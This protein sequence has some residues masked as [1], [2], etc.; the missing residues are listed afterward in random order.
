M[1]YEIVVQ[2]FALPFGIG[3][4]YLADINL[5]SDGAENYTEIEENPHELFEGLGMGRVS[6]YKC[7]QEIESVEFYQDTVDEEEY[8]MEETEEE[9]HIVS[10][11]KE[12]TED[13][14]RGLEENA[15]SRE[16]L[17]EHG[18]EPAD[19]DVF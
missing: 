2:D 18:K 10:W 9:I 15:V 19:G 13:I 14:L 3:T 17:K 12:E 1:G 4:G 8:V 16:M 11:E 5:Y 6:T 7:E